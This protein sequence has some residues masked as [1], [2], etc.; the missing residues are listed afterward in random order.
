MKVKLTLLPAA[1]LLVLKVAVTLPATMVPVPDTA[2]RVPPDKTRVRV[3]LSACDG[4]L[5]V[6]VTVPVT[7]APAVPLDGT[8]RV[9]LT[10]ASAPTVVLPTATLLVG[11]LSAFVVV[12]LLATRTV[13]ELGSTH[14][15]AKLTLQEE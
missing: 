7:V 11:V 5:L 12:I 1:M 2:V 10:S 3:T 15:R 13:P 9:T 6:K 14:V 4:P 8:A